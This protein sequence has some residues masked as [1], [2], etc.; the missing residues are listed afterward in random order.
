MEHGGAVAA[1][2][3]HLKQG[4]LSTVGVEQN[5]TTESH[6][7]HLGADAPDHLNQ[8]FRRKA[9]GAWEVP[10]LRRESDR[11]S[12]QAPDGT[13]HGQPIQHGVEDLISEQGIGDQ[14][15]LG[16]VL[17]DGSERP[18]QRGT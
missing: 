7:R 4:N 15:Q 5:Q 14:G 6:R 11:L 17:L 12:R 3:P 13:L 16:P 1:R 18:D 10:M 9:E 8:Q 2:P